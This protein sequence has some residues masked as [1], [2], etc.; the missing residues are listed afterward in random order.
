[1]PIPTEEGGCSL[2]RFR[3]SRYCVSFATIDTAIRLEPEWKDKNILSVVRSKH[4]TKLSEK[5]DRF[6]EI[7]LKWRTFSGMQSPEKTANG[8]IL[9]L[10]RF[11]GIA[12]FHS[13]CPGYAQRE[14]HV[15]G[16][17]SGFSGSLVQCENTHRHALCL[18]LVRNTVIVGPL[19]QSQSLK[20]SL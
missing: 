4:V 17:P 10:T 5:T 18:V 3:A 8:S 15:A 14:T 19:Y 2:H 7:R 6:D 9:D 11:V 16:H 1:M 12:S 13:S 20:N